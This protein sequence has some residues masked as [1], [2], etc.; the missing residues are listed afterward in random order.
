MYFLALRDIQVRYKQTFLG[1]AWAILQPLFSMVVF[2][3]FFGKLAQI[4]SDGIP[5]PLFSFAALLPWTFFANGINQSTTSLVASANLIKKVYFPRL[6][7]PISAILSGGLD[8]FFSFIVLLGMMLAY[9]MVPDQKIIFLPFLL[10]LA[11]ITS[12]GVGFWLTALNVKYRD[13][14]YAVPFLL[15][16]WL[17][18]SPIVYPSRLLEEPW[19]TLYGFNPMVG[20]IDGFRWALLPISDSPSNIIITST[21]SALILLVSGTIYFQQVEKD[22]ADVA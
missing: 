11:L 20:V 12:L 5:Y 14:R 2:S 21:I 18:A 16:A 13:V 10:L 7:V 4:P 3:F 6:I 22:F 15:Q 1:I 9:K 19:R 8:F 17:F